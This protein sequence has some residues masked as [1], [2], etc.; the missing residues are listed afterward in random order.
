[1]ESWVLFCDG[2]CFGAGGV[3]TSY[4]ELQRDNGEGNVFHYSTSKSELLTSR[5]AWDFAENLSAVA[6]RIE[7]MHEWTVFVVSSYLIMSNGGVG[8]S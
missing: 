7:T 4:G 8:V 3:K 1:M 2:C 5:L 6:E